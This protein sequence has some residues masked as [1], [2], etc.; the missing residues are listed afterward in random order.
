MTK[1]TAQRQ[2]IIDKMK[3]TIGYYRDAD[4]NA[5]A[6]YDA[7]K[8]RNN[9]LQYF[10]GLA[11]ALEA[12]TGKEYHW[13]SGEDGNTWSLVIVEKTNCYPWTK[14]HYDYI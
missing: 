9:M 1:T 7:D 10:T 6:Y 4:K 3:E 8:I 14:E 12:I 11:F 2:I 5:D 13:S